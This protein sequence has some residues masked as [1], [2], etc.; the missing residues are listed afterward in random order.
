MKVFR[1]NQLSSLH[2]ETTV[3]MYQFLSGILRLQD[4][5]RFQQMMVTHKL[6]RIV[7]GCL[8]LMG[9]MAEE[10]FVNVKD[11]TIFKVNNL[12]FVVQ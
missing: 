5:C 8:T 3:R 6:T 11:K 7:K 4:I 12:D 2:V 9:K 1:I 10:H